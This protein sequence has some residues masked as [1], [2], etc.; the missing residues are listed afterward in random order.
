M[1]SLVHV[2]VSEQP[3]RNRAD[4]WAHFWRESQ[5]AQIKRMQ[6]RANE[7]NTGVTDDSPEVR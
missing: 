4:A 6:R 3:S 7:E 1:I 5:F 2:C